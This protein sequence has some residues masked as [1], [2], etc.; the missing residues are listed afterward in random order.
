MGRP[1][2]VVG[3][4]ALATAL[5]VTS[6]GAAAGT[7]A[8][9]VLPLQLSGVP[10]D[11]LVALDNLVAVTVAELSPFRVEIR[12]DLEARLPAERLADA[13]A[14]AALPCAADLRRALG[15]R[16]VLAGSVRELGSHVLFT[17]SLIDTKAG[18][19]RQGKAVA[20]ND[21]DL[22]AEALRGAVRDVL[23]PPPAVSPTPEDGGEAPVVPPGMVQVPSGAFLMG[24]N[25]SLDDACASGTK[26]G[27]RVF[28]SA[29][30]IDR[31]EVTVGDY[32]AC[33]TAGRC[34]PPDSE[35]SC[36]WIERG[37]ESHPI[38]CVTWRQAQDFCAR[39]GKRLPSEA[40]WEKAARGADGRTYP[41]GEDK[42]TCERAVWG[43]GAHANDGCGRES[44]WPVGSKQAGA[45][46]YGVL[47][48]AGN[49]VEWVADWYAPDYGDRSPGRNPPGPSSGTKRVT[50]GGNWVV[51]SASMLR[52]AGRDPDEPGY[53]HA[54]KGFR[55][56][57]AAP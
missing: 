10:G 34:T 51:D 28:L 12:A 52:I 8:V 14:C 3:A 53:Q 18:Q 35:R 15:T 42:P 19:I 50:K 9:L 39:A 40:E 41:W 1:G 16:Y 17:L 29:F 54:G 6:N 4:I 25:P 37:R 44:T 5:L 56:A 55:C 21:P 45:S 46:P 27:H 36:N 32:R 24:C 48:M 47:N 33:V 22:F 2:S 49:V 43:D 7:D 30:F 11:Q 57:R 20:K 23:A 31:T 26:P 38:T 13:L